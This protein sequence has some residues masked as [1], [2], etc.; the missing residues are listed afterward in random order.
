MSFRD[1]V[2]QGLR[3]TAPPATLATSATSEGSHPGKVAK[4]AKVAG[5]PVTQRGLD[6]TCGIPEVETPENGARVE[7]PLRDSIVLLALVFG[8]RHESLR[9]YQLAIGSLYL[10]T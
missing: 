6:A 9:L 1:I 5:P 10:T 3:G 4:V 8:C 2:K 7:R